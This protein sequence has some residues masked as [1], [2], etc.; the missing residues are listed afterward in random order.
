MRV[1]SESV[2]EETRTVKDIFTNRDSSSQNNLFLEKDYLSL[3]EEAKGKFEDILKKQRKDIDELKSELKKS[4][5]Y[6]SSLE[7]EGKDIYILAEKKVSKLLEECEED[8]NALTPE[9]NSILLTLYTSI[10]NLFK[11]AGKKTPSQMS[12]ILNDAMRIN[13]INTIIDLYAEKITE[14]RKQEFENE[15]DRQDKIDHLMRQRD[16]HLRSIEEA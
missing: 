12:E 7:N 14:A 9:L 2:K 11:A 10:D 6:I 4:L 5:N 15:E 8:E 16:I 13:Q 1:I 3:L